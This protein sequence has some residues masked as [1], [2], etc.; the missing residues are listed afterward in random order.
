MVLFAIAVRVVPP[1]R[2]TRQMLFTFSSESYRQGGVGRTSIWRSLFHA[3]NFADF[4]V[5]FWL[6]IRFGID[7]LRG[8]PGTHSRDDKHRSQFAMDSIQHAANGDSE[9]MIEHKSDG[10]ATTQPMATLPMSSSGR[11]APAPME[12]AR[13]PAHGH[14]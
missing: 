14:V 5:S 2:L 8:R 11:A 3:L 4:A 13:P 9:P 1:H 10:L 12:Y 6:A 7:Y